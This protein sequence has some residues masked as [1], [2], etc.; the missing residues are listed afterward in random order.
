MFG[1]VCH[2]AE[3]ALLGDGDD[4]DDGGDEEA[5]DEA[6]D[7][8]VLDPEDVS[9]EDDELLPLP[10]SLFSEGF[11][12]PLPELLDERLSFR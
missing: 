7:D 8:E 1:A 12:E 2:A 4:G 9:E 11:A 6:E 3:A 10:L 5:A